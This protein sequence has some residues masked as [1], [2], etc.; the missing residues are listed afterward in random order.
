MKKRIEKM[1]PAFLS[2]GAAL[3]F[4]SFLF[5]AVGYTLLAFMARL[6]TARQEHRDLF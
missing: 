4:G 6:S 3:F 2:L 5:M 1:I